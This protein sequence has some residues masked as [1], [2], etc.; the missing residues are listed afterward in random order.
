M[1]RSRTPKRLAITVLGL[2]VG[3]LTP[4]GPAFGQASPDL[5]RPTTTDLAADAARAVDEAPPVPPEVLDFQLLTDEIVA[6]L[7]RMPAEEWIVADLAASLGGDIEAT[8]AFVRDHIGFDPYAGSLRSPQATLAARAGNG[9]DRALLLQ[10]LLAEAPVET[11]FATGSAD[12]DV[13]VGRALAG[14][15]DPLPDPTATEIMPFATEAL[16]NRARRDHAAVVEALGADYDNLGAGATDPIPTDHAWLQVRES[17]GD[18]IDLDPSLTDAL[19]GD[20]LAEATSTHDQLPPEQRHRLT[21]RLIAESET[22]DG[23]S[24]ET[25]LD[26]TIEA[27]TAADRDMWLLF[28][29]ESTAPGSAIA[30]ALGEASAFVPVLYIHG[31]PRA[32]SAFSIGAD[33]GEGGGNVLGDALDGLGGLGGGEAEASGAGSDGATAGGTDPDGATS[34]GLTELR[35]EIVSSGPGLE[36]VAVERVLFTGPSEEEPPGFLDDMHHL[37]VSNGGFD[38]RRLAV[39]RGAV[40]AMAAEILEDPEDTSGYRLIDQLLP[41]AVADRT[42]AAVSEHV[43][44]PALG[45]PGEVRA[46]V[47]RR[48]AWIISHGM[49]IDEGTFDGTIDLALDGVALAGAGGSGA[50]S[51]GGSGGGSDPTG[52]ARERLWYG[53]L[54]TALETEVARKR[55]RR[56]GPGATLLSVSRDTGAGLDR[57]DGSAAG[58]DVSALATAIEGGAIALG[59]GYADTGSFWSVDPVTGA[60]TSVQEPGIRPSRFGGSYSGGGGGYYRIGDGYTSQRLNAPARQAGGGGLEYQVLQ[61]VT[62]VGAIATAFGVGWAI[63]RAIV[64]VLDWM[65]SD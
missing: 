61:A 54:Q 59:A 50:G 44:L 20:T 18:W 46:Y 55:V 5:S 7:E 2:T 9:W 35:L 1:F 40:T 51:G 12:P 26:T 53:V 14:V 45:T 10:A 8:F 24:V 58:S 33:S 23:R 4:L 62:T 28:G 39:A 3:V 19:P 21:V 22:S 52:L 36:P 11:R 32:G 49:D 48:R 63:G 17:G 64:W 65:Y 30:S 60:T 29:A 47:D 31:D 38:L 6:V 27:S 41:W 34:L 42:L 25:V 56:S 57:L 13:L 43:I 37:L 16:L 15:A